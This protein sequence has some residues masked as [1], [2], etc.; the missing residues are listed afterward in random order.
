MQSFFVAG[1]IGWRGRLARG[2][3]VKGLHAWK[4]FQALDPYEEGERDVSKSPVSIRWL[5]RPGDGGWQ[6]VRQGASGGNVDTKVEEVRQGGTY[7]KP[8]LADSKACVEVPKT[9]I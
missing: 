1:T 6:E 9:L 7:V 3:E 4:Q 2:T 8:R 5:S